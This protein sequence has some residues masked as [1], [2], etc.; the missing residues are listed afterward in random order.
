MFLKNKVIFNYTSSASSSIS[1]NILLNAVN[2]N[3]TASFPSQNNVAYASVG[4]GLTNDES[5]T[6]YDLVN[7]FQ[8]SLGRGVSNPNAFIT[9]WDT[10]LTGSGTSNSSSIVLPLYGTQAITA[11]WGDGTTSNISSSTQVDR[12]HSYATPGIYTVTI[13]GSGEGFRFDNSGD[14]TKLLDVGQWGTTKL[15]HSGTSFRPVFMAVLI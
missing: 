1:N 6:Y 5:R 4:A 8:T 11:S 13:T 3:G 9:T 2:V 15:G 12:T 14:K 10:R 7:T